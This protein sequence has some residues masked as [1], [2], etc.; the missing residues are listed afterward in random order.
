MNAVGGAGQLEAVIAFYANYTE[1][2]DDERLQEWPNFFTDDCIYQIIPRENYDNHLQLCT[3]QADGK[4]MLLDRVQGILRTQRFGPRRCRRFYSGLKIS[5]IEGNVI[6]VRQNVLVVQT[7][8]DEPSKILLCGASYDQLESNG[9][10]HIRQRIV[11][12]DTDTIDN[13][14]IFPV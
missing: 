9:E 5:R 6:D 3:V 2:L 12:S 8:T 4:N 11:V 13:A 1:V 14:L 10:L 7:L